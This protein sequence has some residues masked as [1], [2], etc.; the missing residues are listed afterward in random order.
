MPYHPARL[1]AA[2]GAVL[3]AA[4]S[5]AAATVT[6]TADYTL[7]YSVSAHVEPDGGFVSQAVPPVSYN[8][9]FQFQLGPVSEVI[10]SIAPGQQLRTLDV[11]LTFQP[12]DFAPDLL[13]QVNAQALNLPVNTETLQGFIRTER[14]ETTA[15]DLIALPGASNAFSYDEN[16]FS[17]PLGDIQSLSRS[18]RA[19]QQELYTSVGG[20]LA[21]TSP[22][23][24]AAYFLASLQLWSIGSFTADAGPQLSG[25]T[26]YSGINK[27]GPLRFTNVTFVDDS[28][29]A[30]PESATWALMISGFAATGVA[31]RRR[32]P[33]RVARA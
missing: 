19:N 23:D 29:S 9:S 26:I 27:A 17:L 30:V 15:G 6:F 3:L 13:A 20:G 10:T 2:L 16:R 25:P 22:D 28:V 11:G 21:G 7:I 1:A 24:I 5:P 18:V 4:A 14:L 12:F 31:L 8:G 32:R 33:A